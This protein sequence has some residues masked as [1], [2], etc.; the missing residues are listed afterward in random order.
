MI[1]S[2]TCFKSIEG[3]CI[4][5]ILTNKKSYFQKSNTF[6]TGI[7]DHHLLIYTILKSTYEKLPAKKQNYRSFKSF[8]SES[9]ERDLSYKLP[10]RGL[11]IFSDLNSAIK[12]SLDENAPIKTRVVRGNNKPYMN[13]Q[14][15]KAIMK[16][17]ALKNKANKSKC[18]TDYEAYKK[19]RNFVANLN[20]KCKKAFFAKV[21]I[22]SNKKS[23]WKFCKSVFPCKSGVSNEKITLEHNGHIVTDEKTVANIFNIHFVNIVKSLNIPEWTPKSILKLTNVNLTKWIIQVFDL[24]TAT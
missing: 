19:Q 20:K 13:K 5:L 23:M 4:D 22:D 1:E 12:I 9:F 24:Y 21:S 17:S 8:S 3:S 16:R 15:R 2:P 18:Q 6:E 10:F 11:G 14:L 7:S